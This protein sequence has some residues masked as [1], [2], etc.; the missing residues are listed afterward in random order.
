MGNPVE[1]GNTSEMTDGTMKAVSVEGHEVLLARVGEEYYASDNRCPHMGGILSD[2][3][4]EGAVVT[5]PRHGSQFDLRNGEVVRWLRGS[6]LV[7]GIGKA[8]KPSKS[9][10]MYRVTVED[11]SLKVEI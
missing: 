5:C 6:G 1:I 9:L 10:R 7:S 2:G 4:L 11:D 3:R 8:L